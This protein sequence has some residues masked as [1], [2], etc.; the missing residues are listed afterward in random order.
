MRKKQIILIKDIIKEENKDA[1]LLEEKFDNA[2][3][4]IAIG[5][6]GEKCAA[7]DSTQCIKVL[8]S[9]DNMNEMDALEQF[10]MTINSVNNKKNKP[11]FI[12]DFRKTKSLN[13][14]LDR[15]QKLECIIKK[16]K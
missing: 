10:Q 5:Y 15:D 9:Q 2:L 16:I 12:S 11:I 13:M 14:S 3:I 8:I 7:Y 4:G 1:L 6:G